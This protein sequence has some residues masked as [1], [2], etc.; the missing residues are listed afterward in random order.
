MKDGRGA[1][2]RR[3]GSGARDGERQNKKKKKQAI[4]SMCS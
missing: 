3:T 1:E 2:R 4:K